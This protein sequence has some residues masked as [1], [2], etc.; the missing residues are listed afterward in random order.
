MPGI[1]FHEDGHFYE[2]EPDGNGNDVPQ[3]DRRMKVNPETGEFVPAD[4]D[5]QPHNDIYGARGAL[6]VTPS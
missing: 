6:A 2:T 1:C 3:L 5:T 4:E